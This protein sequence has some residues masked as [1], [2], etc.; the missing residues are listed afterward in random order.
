MQEK[1]KS[2]KKILKYKPLYQ[3]LP[4]SFFIIRTELAKGKN[5]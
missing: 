3:L 2:A 1:R 4:P 5:T